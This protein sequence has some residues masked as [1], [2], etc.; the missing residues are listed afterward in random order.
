MSNSITNFLYS[1]FKQNPCKYYENLKN[2][3]K[4]NKSLVNIKCEDF[5]DG[6]MKKGLSMAFEKFLLKGSK[7]GA[8][9][10]YYFDN[11]SAAWRIEDGE[12]KKIPG[13]PL[14]IN[15]LRCLA[16]TKDMAELSKFF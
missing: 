16:L 3:I 11:K 8:K 6:V 15:N 12:C 10:S 1:R 9:M 13:M 14:F 4:T 7:I 5:S 2:D